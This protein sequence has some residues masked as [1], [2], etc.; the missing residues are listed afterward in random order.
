[1]PEPEPSLIRTVI[2]GG[3]LMGPFV[4]FALL[5]IVTTLAYYFRR[6]RSVKHLV[7]LLV[8][9]LGFGLLGLGQWVFH[10]HA[11]HL[12]MALSGYPDEMQYIEKAVRIGRTTLV[13]LSA[14]GISFLTTAIGFAFPLHDPNRVGP[15]APGRS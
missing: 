7:S 4:L 8:F 15:A 14:A 5:W 10:W 11:V 1:M 12:G 6:N 2:E 13:V 9:P 3:V